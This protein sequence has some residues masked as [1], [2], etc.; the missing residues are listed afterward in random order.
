MASEIV[1]E[2]RI[3]GSLEV[4]AILNTREDQLTAQ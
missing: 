2:S 3:K 1:Q 4:D